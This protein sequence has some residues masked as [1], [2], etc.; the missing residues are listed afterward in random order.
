MTVI[1]TDTFLHRGGFPRYTLAL[2]HHVHPDGTSSDET[3]V[4]IRQYDN[5]IDFLVTDV[6]DSLTDAYTVYHLMVGA[7]Q[8]FIP[9]LDRTA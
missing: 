4:L 5:S 1:M 2:A 9:A 8:P 3:P 6:Y 7:D